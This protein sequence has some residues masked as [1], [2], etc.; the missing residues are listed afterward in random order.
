VGEDEKYG[1]MIQNQSLLSL[2]SIVTTIAVF[3]FIVIKVYFYL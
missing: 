3:V 1:R 2:L